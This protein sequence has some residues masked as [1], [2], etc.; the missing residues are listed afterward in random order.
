[1]DNFAYTLQ[2]KQYLKQ[3][4]YIFN[5]KYFRGINEKIIKN[6]KILIEE[7]NHT[8]DVSKNYGKSISCHRI[9][10][11]VNGNIIYE[12][13][14][15]FIVKPFFQYIKHKNENEYFVSGNDLLDFSVFNITKNQEYKYVNEYIINENYEGDCNNEFWYITEWKYNPKNNYVAINGQDGMNCETITIFDFTKPE[16]LPYHFR[17]LSQEIDKKYNDGTCT[18]M[19]WVE[20]NGLLIKIGEE[21]TQEIIINEDE[22][23][24]VLNKMQKG[25][26]IA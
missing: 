24:K 1:M 10:L 17:N 6:Y 26:Y 4:E 14:S 21:Q 7:Y 12:N 8:Y 16:K 23:E 9:K 19:E 5:E 22:I 2:Y 18:A 3:F 11:L 20:N 13:K 15:V 25:A